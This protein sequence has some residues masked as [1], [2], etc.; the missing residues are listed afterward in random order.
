MRPRFIPAGAG[1]TAAHTSGVPTS[2]VHPRRR[3]EHSTASL[4]ASAKYGSSPQARGTRHQRERPERPARFIPAGAGNTLTCT[5]C[6]E[7]RSVHPRRRGEHNP[8]MSPRRAPPGSSPQARGTHS[9]RD[10]NHLVQRFIPAG[11]GNTY[12]K[13][14]VDLCGS[15]HPRRRGE[16]LEQ[17]ITR[18]S[19]RGSSPQAR[20]THMQSDICAGRYRFIPAGAGNTPNQPPPVGQET[21]HPRRRGEHSRG[22][23]PRRICAGSSPQA[24]GTL[25]LDIVYIAE[26]WFIPAGAGN[27]RHAACHGLIPPV[28]PRRRGEH[29]IV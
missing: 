15:V 18:D 1:N 28:H 3:G 14:A 24:R 8:N 4:L 27:T 29:I 25:Q 11:A 19:Y 12:P 6:L 10:A 23:R 22:S 21:V 20:G 9:A 2:A 16:H 26:G 5:V 7:S 13:T 17:T